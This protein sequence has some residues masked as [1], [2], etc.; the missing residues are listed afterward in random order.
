MDAEEPNPGRLA[1][2]DQ[3]RTQ[4]RS[5]FMTAL[6]GATMTAVL[7]GAAAFRIN[8]SNARSSVKIVT[9]TTTFPPS[10]TTTTEPETTLSTLFVPDSA[11][12][13]TKSATT[14]TKPSATT[15]TGP[16]T[17]T[18]TTTTTVAPAPPTS[19]T[20]HATAKIAWSLAPTSVTVQAGGQVS[21]TITA[22]NTGH[23]TGTVTVPPCPAAPQ[24]YAVARPRAG[25]PL[26][27]SCHPGPQSLAVAPG[28]HYSWS[29]TISATS[30]ATRYGS[31]LAPGLYNVRVNGSPSM[32]LHMTVVA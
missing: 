26:A 31:P 15:T 32:Y 19:P 13:D 7:A 8:D 10:T 16:T 17:T 1:Q 25:A 20:T 5:V 29:D 4:R 30:D 3:Q 27:N 18:S 24:P 28:Q 12:S 6:I 11:P 9:T 2:R 21:V 14:T 23:A 22:T